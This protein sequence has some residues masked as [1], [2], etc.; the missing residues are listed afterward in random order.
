MT[1]ENDDAC[2]DVIPGRDEVARPESISLAVE[3]RFRARG[4]TPAP[5]ND[6]SANTR[7]DPSPHHRIRV[8]PQVKPPP[9]ASSITRSPRL[10]RRSATAS[11]SASGIEAA[12][13]LP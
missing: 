10:M 11:V 12:E 3:Y 9:M 13:V 7:R 4:L 8:A 1:R 6:G 5:R 2:S